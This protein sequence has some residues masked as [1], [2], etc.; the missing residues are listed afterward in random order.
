MDS[1]VELS[2]ER[3][4][5]LYACLFTFYLCTTCVCGIVNA[6]LFKVAIILALIVIDMD[7]GPLVGY[8]ALTGVAVG[9]LLVPYIACRYMCISQ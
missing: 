3:G 9:I 1:T 2:N 8:G 5:G 4:W 7:W 6:V